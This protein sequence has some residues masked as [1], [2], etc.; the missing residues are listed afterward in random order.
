MVGLEWVRTPADG[1][2]AQSTPDSPAWEDSAA[3]PMFAG[4][5]QW[6]MGFNVIKSIALVSG[7]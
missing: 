2:R 1:R 5:Q 7:R 6:Y 4:D 3:E